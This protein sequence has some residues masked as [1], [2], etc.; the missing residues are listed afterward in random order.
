MLE[1]F[2]LEGFPAVGELRNAGE[3]HPLIRARAEQLVRSQGCA[4]AAIREEDGHY[5]QSFWLIN[6][7]AADLTAE[8]AEALSARPDVRAISLSELG[9]EPP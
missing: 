9:V 4:L 3:E 1:E 8:Q 6:A 2:P 7:F 5:I